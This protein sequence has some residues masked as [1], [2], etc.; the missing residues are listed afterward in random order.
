[1]S[2]NDLYEKYI[3]DSPVTHSVFLLT[4][5]KSKVNMFLQSI[6]I[7]WEISVIFYFVNHSA[8]KREVVGDECLNL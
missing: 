2:I 5:T 8:D 1:M 6:C 7:R 3:N 4:K